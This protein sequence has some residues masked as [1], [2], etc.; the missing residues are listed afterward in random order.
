MSGSISTEAA[1]GRAAVIGIDIGGERVKSVI[2]VAGRIIDRSIRLRDAPIT[3]ML[4]PLIEAAIRDHGVTAA[5]IGIAGLVDHP[6]GRFVWG[7][8]LSDTG[9]DVSGLLRPLLDSSVVDNDANCAAY[10]EWVMG[11]AVGRRVALTISVGTGIGAGLVVDGEIWRGA[12]F[13][14]EVG[15]MQIGGGDLECP[16]GRRGC[17]ETMVS[18]RQLGIAAARLG[19]EPTAEALARSAA[20]G[21][22]RAIA[23]LRLAGGWLGVGVANLMLVLDP[24]VVVVAGGVSLAG[25]LILDA[26]RDRIASGLPG[27]GHRPEVDLVNASH[28]RWAAAIG[29]AHLAA[30]HRSSGALHDRGDE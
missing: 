25:D 3:A 28:G 17:W 13:A 24:D 4:P 21:S 19:L 26:A 20:G 22:P 12:G 15:H 14:G 1:N 30:E 5:G 23:A 10:A 2:M 6:R 8:H 18:G 9:V 16:C 11:A 29:A 27:R 7:P